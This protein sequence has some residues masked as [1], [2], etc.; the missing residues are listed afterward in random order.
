MSIGEHYD[1]RITLMLSEISRFSGGTDG[2]VLIIVTGGHC[3]TWQKIREYL[4]PGSVRNNL[5]SEPV[6]VLL[7]QRR[8]EIKGNP[9]PISFE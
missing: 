9:K 4:L 5:A 6:R 7:Q 1:G 3:K 2:Q 8:S